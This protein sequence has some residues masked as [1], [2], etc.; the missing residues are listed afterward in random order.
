MQNFKY[1]FKMLI[2]FVG[3]R[4][5]KQKIGARKHLSKGVRDGK[6]SQPVDPEINSRMGRRSQGPDPPA[7]SDLT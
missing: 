1:I 5:R 7:L 4:S 6:V 3:W 2:G